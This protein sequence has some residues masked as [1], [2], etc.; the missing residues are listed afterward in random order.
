MT[1]ERPEARVGARLRSYAEAGVRRVDHRAVA[2]AILRGS[3]R[4][5]RTRR[6]GGR[7]LVPALVGLLLLALAGAGLVVG[8]RLLQDQREARMVE[9]PVRTM[10]LEAVAT[11]APDQAES[12][13][14]AGPCAPM[15]QRAITWG[16]EDWARPIPDAGVGGPATNGDILV[17]LDGQSASAVLGRLDPSPRSG[18]VLV[19]SSEGLSLPYAPGFD[20]AAQA[21]IVASPDGRAVAIEDGDLGVAGCGDPVVL[22]AEGG[23]RRPFPVGAY[24]L[25][26]DLAW[27]PDGGALYGVRRPTV[28][29]RSRPY[30]DDGS[31]AM[32][33]GEGVVLRWDAATGET[34]ELGSPCTDCPLG[35]LFVAPDGAASRR[36]HRVA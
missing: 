32:G 14:G 10:A 4:D 31:E 19:E 26:T 28:D 23:T 9:A 1:D 25:V 34:T 17:A 20:I 21:R 3:D 7:W 2:E 13:V 5:R 35:Q 15:V 36:E 33:R 29:A 18:P 12:L 16:D 6:F 11:S 24:Q 30:V 8:S 22:L 27:A